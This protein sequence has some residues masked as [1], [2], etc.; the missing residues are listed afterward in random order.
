MYIDAVQRGP[1]VIIWTRDEHGKLERY[2]VP[3]PYYCYRR[4]KNGDLFS[5]FGDRVKKVEFP[6]R[7]EYESFTK[8]RT[9]LFES[10]IS[11]LYKTLSDFF[12]GVDDTPWNVSLFDIE[13]HVDLSR[14][15]GFP[16]PE[17]PYGEVNAITMFNV[18]EQ[19]YHVIALHE[20]SRLKLEDP[21]HPVEVYQCATEKQVLD[22]FIRLIEDTDVLSAW[23]GE[24]YD[25]PYL[26]TRMQR[27]YGESDG[28]KKMCR[29]G[30]KAT[31]REVVDDFNNTYIKYS[32]VGRI[33][34]DYMDLFKNFSFGEKESY[35]LDAIC[36]SEV[37]A[38]KLPYPGDLGELYRDDPQTFF[39]YSL[40][41][42]RLMRLLDEKV[43]HLSLAKT[44]CRQATIKYNDI[45]GSIKYLE[46]AIRNY[47]HYERENPVV[48]P[49]RDP[50]AVKQ[51]FPGAFVMA[52]QPGVY[53][54]V[55]S[56]DL[57][58]LYPSVIRSINI[59]PE[60][61]QFQCVDNHEGFV[62][63]AEN[64]TDIIQIRDV[65]EGDIF[66]L[67]ANEF[68]ELMESSDMT[69]SAFG[70]VFSHER[71]LIPEVLDIWYEERKKTK[72]LSKD[73]A[74]QG[75]DAKAKY[76]DMIQNIKK[77]GLNSLYGTI[78]NK[79]SRFYSLALAASVTLT[80]QMIERFQCWAADRLV[81]SMKESR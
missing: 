37:G 10:D 31:S 46:H 71:G 27:L 50:D 72:Q 67:P 6:D 44:M 59:S 77:L 69:V 23:N 76:Y 79:H 29:D 5:M 62:K 17:N 26:I 56:I 32:L 73:C 42:V 74:K 51:D 63:I 34:I 70:A 54:W 78:S 65:E 60:T 81:E 30:F 41:D 68:R 58:S 53:S 3:A 47:A 15:E 7:K 14:G 33:H 22:T 1:D 16:M 28:L 55:S 11:P 52:T 45:F 61:H 13:T 64:S 43:K 40:H 35:S 66:E 39:E 25:I 24:R 18:W 21:D 9:D 2:N 48:L 8:G 49:D 12:H 75:D 19:K 4:S 38:K 57:A 80:G 36:E 20:T